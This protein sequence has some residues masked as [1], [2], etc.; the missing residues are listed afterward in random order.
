MSLHV[1]L[2][3]LVTW[4]LNNWIK[5]LCFHNHVDFK[6]AKVTS[7]NCNLYAWLYVTGSSHNS[8]NCYER[9]NLL[10]SNLSEFC[11][12]P[13]CSISGYNHKLVIAR[14]FGRN[15]ILCR[16]RILDL[17]VVDATLNLLLLNLVDVEFTLLHQ[18]IKGAEVF[19]FEVDRGLRHIVVNYFRKNVDV[20]CCVPLNPLNK[21]SIFLG[22]KNE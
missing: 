15:N 13:F 18:D 17:L 8:S 5:L 6:A 22:S 16:S 1:I 19:I 7:G 12:V 14:Q 21:M 20:S 11:D 9:S 2:P 4:T 3:T 10:C